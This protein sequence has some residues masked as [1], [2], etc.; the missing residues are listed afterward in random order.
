MPPVT[1]PAHYFVIDQEFSRLQQRLA[2][3]VKH[4]EPCSQIIRLARPLAALRGWQKYLRQEVKKLPDLFDKLSWNLLAR[5]R[6]PSRRQLSRHLLPLRRSVRNLV[7]LHQSVRRHFFPASHRQGQRLLLN[8]LK[9]VLASMSAIFTFFHH[10][11]RQADQTTLSW[12]QP[13]H[14]QP[15]MT[16]FTRWLRQQARQESPCLLRRAW[17]YSRQWSCKKLHPLL[18][19]NQGT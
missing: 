18:E 3:A 12:Q 6:R 15:E 8:C 9:K 16:A 11:L 10:A 14:C 1:I 5:G 19:F 7:L 17:E 4:K 2:A 13:L